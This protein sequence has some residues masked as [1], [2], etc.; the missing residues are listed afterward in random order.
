MCHFAHEL[1]TNELEFLGGEI[2][3]SQFTHRIIERIG[4]RGAEVIEGF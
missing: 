4:M 3:R 2:I 1:D